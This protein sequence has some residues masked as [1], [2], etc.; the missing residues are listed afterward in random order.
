[1]PTTMSL[2]IDQSL[3]PKDINPSE[4][5]KVVV[6]SLKELLGPERKTFTERRYILS[7]SL[8]KMIGL[9]WGQCTPKIREDIMGTK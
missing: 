8:A 6:E 1:M 9:V 4:E 5:D 3:D 2:T 7:Q